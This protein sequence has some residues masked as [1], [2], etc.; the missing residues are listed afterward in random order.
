MNT[1]QPFT[2]I[3]IIFI[4]LGIILVILPLIAQYIPNLEKL[5]WIIIWVYKTDNFTFATSPILLI[6][7]ILSFIINYIRQWT[8][9]FIPFFLTLAVLCTLG[10]VWFLLLPG[11]YCW[12]YKRYRSGCHSRGI[13]ESPRLICFA[14]TML[15]GNL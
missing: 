8:L 10:I 2:V 11:S 7:T 13:S 3:G 14:I 9:E 6:I 15:P 5:P 12:Y 4:V 1:F